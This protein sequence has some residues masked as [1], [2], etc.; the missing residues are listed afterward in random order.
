MDMCIYVFCRYNW[1][2]EFKILLKIYTLGCKPSRSLIQ[3]RKKKTHSENKLSLS[4]QHKVKIDPL[5]TSSICQFLTSVNTRIW[6][7]YPSNKH[8][9]CIFRERSWLWAAVSLPQLNYCILELQCI[10]LWA[11]GQPVGGYWLEYNVMCSSESKMKSVFCLM[12]WY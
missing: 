5:L 8:Y 11:V 12:G 4:L 1:R 2:T 6:F 7:L 3:M 9:I 10:H